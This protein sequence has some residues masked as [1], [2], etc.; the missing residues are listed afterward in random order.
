MQTHEFKL[1][2]GVECEVRELIGEDSEI[3]TK[4]KNIESGK[5]LDMLLERIIVR[6]GKETNIT[7]KFV[8]EML[9]GDRAKALFEARQ[10]SYDFPEEYSTNILFGKRKVP[11]S[12]Q[13]S[14]IEQRNYS[15][16]C[17]NYEQVRDKRIIHTILPKSQKPVFF[18]CLDG[19]A[20][21][22]MQKINTDES[23]IITIINLRKPSYLT[24]E[25]KE[26]SL[27]LLALPQ[28]DLAH[29]Y[30]EIEKA[31][32]NIETSVKVQNPSD[33]N[34]EKLINLLAY[35]EFFFPSLI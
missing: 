18:Y 5:A 14:E 9:A 16:Q 35:K 32:G 3:F 4:K 12:I 23:S 8:S 13:I 33:Q 29:L 19:V 24:D 22:S 21:Q 2:T 26:V 15:F 1:L 28:K 7:R 31:E 17:E 10:F 27:N 20:E 34:E 6:V 11:F 25:G 30:S